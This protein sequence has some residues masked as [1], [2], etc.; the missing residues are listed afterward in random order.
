MPKTATDPKKLVKRLLEAKEA[1]YNSTPV[2]SDADFDALEDE[3]RATDPENDYFNEVGIQGNSKTK[4]KH[5]IPMLSA[6]KAKTP[7]EAWAWLEKIGMTQER[8]VVEPKIDGLSCTCRYKGGKL[9]Y[10]ATRGDGK[11]GQDI[12]HVAGLVQGIPKTID[13]DFEVE[14]RGELY[15]P[16]NSKVPNPDGKPLR[17]IA[18]GFINRKGEKH[19]LNDLKWVKFIAYQVINLPHNPKISF[20]TELGKLEWLRQ[21]GFFVIESQ[22]FNTRKG[23]DTIHAKYLSTKRDEWEF[24][25]DGLVLVVDNIKKHDGIDS[26]YEV[27]HH[28]HYNL[29]LKP[30]SVGKETKLVSI[31]WNVSR[32]GRLQPVAIVEPV[33]I[34]G[35]VIRR[36]TLNNLENVANLKLH[37]GDRVIIERANDVIPFFKQNLATHT[38]HSKALIP[39]T[40]PSCGKAVKVVGIHLVC[41]NAKCEEQ[42]VL[43]I[44]H[45]VKNCEMEAFSEASV[46][47]LFEAGKIKTI[48]DLYDLKAE[49]FKGAE[50]FGPSKT[51]NALAQIEATKSMNIR[52]FVDRLGIDLVGERAIEKLG[53]E[54]ADE[55]LAFTDK[56]FV[57]GKNLVEFVADNLAFVKDL[58]A[59]V[60]IVPIVK[61]SATGGKL[62][63]CTGAGPKPRHELQ[64]LIKQK[65]DV[66]IDRV[67]KDTQIL[68][69]E[70]V[71]GDSTKLQ[72]ARKLGVKLVSYDEYF[73]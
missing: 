71:N 50:G 66:S 15:I 1:Y 32:L 21:K 41:D 37:A 67:T 49:D 61:A 59:C 47:A 13:E 8:I 57:I 19:S 28:H 18:V 12:S 44:V 7:D 40:C 58:L 56:T 10:V 4:L 31:E 23:L 2:M 24:E 38:A 43:K 6:G 29:A 11:V 25:T 33:E 48:K 68:V 16:K 46:R 20:D 70:D 36:C 72:K 54:T 14:I 42:A 5:E 73:A 69:C 9:V 30:P 64:L 27:R 35:A 17:N 22:D 52:Q 3:L 51:K 65:G 45:W 62:V 39:D 60:D 63:C 34:G 53:I 55:L 26:L